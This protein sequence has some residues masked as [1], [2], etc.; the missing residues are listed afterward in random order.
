MRPPLHNPATL[1]HEDLI[2]AADRRQPVRDHE[3]RPPMAQGAQPILDL[4]FALGIETG[5][6]F[7]EHENPRVGENRPRDGDA[8]A[9]AA[10]QLHAALADDGVV[11]LVELRDEF[12]TVRDARHF[13]DLLARR[14][15][16]RERDVLGD[17]AI[18]EEVVLQYHAKLSAIIGERHGREIAP[19]HEHAALLR[20]MKCQ[21]QTDQCALAGPR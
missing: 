4:G 20:P 6:R 21:H 3:R 18:E 10:G 15:R 8:L 14:M 9:L 11:F 17:R 19:I 13:L 7:V 1:E 5:G 12:V 2:R 16:P